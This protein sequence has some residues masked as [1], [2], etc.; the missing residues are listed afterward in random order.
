MA[1]T[2]FK[3]VI[4]P[5]RFSYLHVFEPHSFETDKEPRYSA[6]II[7]PKSDTKLVEQVK[8]AIQDAYNAAVTERWGGKKPPMDK[9][10]CLRDG[11]E[12]NADGEVRDAAYSGCY[13]LNAKS[14]QQPGVVDKSRQPILNSEEFY[15]GCWGY[16][17]IAFSGFENNGNKGISC[18][19]NNL[20]KTKDDEPLGGARTSAA[21]DFA[22][23]EVDE[24]D[25]I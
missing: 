23:V 3:A 20:M 18:F 21:D 1:Q 11:D 14:R 13:F 24:S 17:S 19:L 25:D 22:A 4:G 9:A 8:K 12:P 6:S 2:S 5:V 15:S 10:T 7:I 16:A